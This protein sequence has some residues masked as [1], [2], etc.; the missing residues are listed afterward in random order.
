M[1]L[2][3]DRDEL[4]ELF[5]AWLLVSLVFSVAFTRGNLFSFSFLINFILSGFTVG[6]AFLCHELAH[7]FVAQHYHA[8]AK[9]IANTR[10]LLLSLLFAF[11]G[12]ILIAPGGVVISGRLNRKQHAN[13]A[14]AGIFA[15]ISLA[16]LF[17]ALLLFRILAP[18]TRFGFQ[19]NMW[20]AFFNLLPFP[21]FDG[22]NIMAWNRRLY[23]IL[24]FVA[25]SLLFISFII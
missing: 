8:Y 24:I 9:F 14:A 23:I 3:F 13:I 5:R 6:I 7:K 20:L 12:F 15:N 4:R 21:L 10:M 2:R 17:L 25:I 11:F 22:Q 19:I 16:L 18:I 1:L